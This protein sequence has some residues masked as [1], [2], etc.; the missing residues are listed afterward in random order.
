MNDLRSMARALGGDVMKD[1]NGQFYVLCPGPGHSARDRSLSVTPSKKVPG[2]FVVNSFANN[3]WRSCRDYVS[4]RLGRPVDR[5]NRSERPQRAADRLSASAPRNNDAQWLPIWKEA[6]EPRTSIVEQYLGVR[7]L[8]LSD[9]LVGRVVRFHPRCPFGKGVR[10]P[11]MVTLFR[12]I[13]TDAPQAIHR[14][15]L[16]ADGRKIDRKMKGRVSGAAMKIDPDVDV[17]QGLTIC[18]GFETGLA[19]RAMNFRP[20]WALGSAGAITD[21]PVLAGVDCLTILGEPDATS[22]DAVEQCGNRWTDAGREV[23][24]VMSKV[25][26]DL[27][28]AYRAIAS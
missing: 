28:D 14:T 4:N 11:C 13:T 9:D 12:S 16:T 17:E 3:D 23:R 7:G 22:A 24:V 15:A 21:F 25:G 18:E 19:G 5:G 26:G 10:H 2:G 1:A 27:N 8:D 20:V 6:G